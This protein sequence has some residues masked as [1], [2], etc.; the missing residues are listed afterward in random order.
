MDTII[1]KQELLD[2]YTDLFEP[3]DIV[4]AMAIVSKL[5]EVAKTLVFAEYLKDGDDKF[6]YA[7]T[8]VDRFTHARK[9][10]DILKA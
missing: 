7:S 8:A 6:D 9:T 1:P 4:E 10:F 3:L 2:Y 5:E